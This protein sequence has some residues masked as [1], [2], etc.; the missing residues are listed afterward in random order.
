MTLRTGIVMGASTPIHLPQGQLRSATMYEPLNR[1]GRARLP[2]SSISSVHQIAL[3][4]IQF[5]GRPQ[6]ACSTPRREGCRDPAATSWPSRTPGPW[7]ED[8][9][10]RSIEWL[11][12]GCAPNSTTFAGAHRGA[13]L[14]DRGQAQCRAGQIRVSQARTVAP[15]MLEKFCRG[16]RKTRPEAWFRRTYLQVC[17]RPHRGSRR[18]RDSRHRR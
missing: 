3:R 4:R 11:R 12:T 16:M 6:F 13:A 10:K 7:A 1:H 5:D 17:R 9:L 14:S 18:R 8:K 2:R 15:I